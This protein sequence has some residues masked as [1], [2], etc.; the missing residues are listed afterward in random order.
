MLFIV[1]PPQQ[2]H[3]YQKAQNMTNLSGKK[4][5][6]VEQVEEIM[7]EWGKYSVED[8]AERFQLDK[9]IIEAT[10]EYLRKLKRTSNKHELS[11]MACH[12]D[13]RLESIVRCAGEKH[14]YV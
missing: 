4:L 1:N 13:D 10:A 12:R 3:R 11:V 8:F 5:P 7:K 2:I 6:T 9:E 14:G